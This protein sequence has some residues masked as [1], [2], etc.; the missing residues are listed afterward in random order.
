MNS[1]TTESFKKQTTT[2]QAVMMTYRDLIK[3]IGKKAKGM[4]LYIFNLCWD[5]QGLP[6]KW[7]TAIIKTLLKDGK[8]PKEISSYRPISLTSCLGKLLEKIVADRL[9]FVLESKGLLAD[10]Q[11]GFRQNRCTTDQILKMTQLATDHIQT[12]RAESEPLLPSLSMRRHTTKS[13]ATDYSSKCK[14]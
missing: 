10:L 5:G 8:D 2:K 14:N 7:L 9:T 11:A 3:H 6:N 1:A 4:I 13:G 12:R